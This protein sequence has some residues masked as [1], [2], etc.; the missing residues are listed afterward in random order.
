VS[1]RKHS[2]PPSSRKSQLD[3]AFYLREVFRIRILDH[4]SEPVWGQKRWDESEG[5]WTQF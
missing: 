1:I 2:L 5:S 4:S 3:L